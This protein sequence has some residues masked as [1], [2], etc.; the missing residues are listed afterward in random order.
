MTLL[1]AQITESCLLLENFESETQ[2]AKRHTP[3]FMRVRLR[4]FKKASFDKMTNDVV[5]ST[6][7]RIT[8][9]MGKF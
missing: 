5:V 3:G 4:V 1:L 8:F 2:N 7:H 6:D 9:A